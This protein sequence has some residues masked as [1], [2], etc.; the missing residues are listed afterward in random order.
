MAMD[1]TR[2]F[3]V[4]GGVFVESGFDLGPVGQCRDVGQHSF[5][6]VTASLF[7]DLAVDASEAA[8][9][10][11]LEDVDDAVAAQHPLRLQ[12]P[13]EGIVPVS[14]RGAPGQGL[15][16]FRRGEPSAGND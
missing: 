12:A 1:P 13:P 5:E 6:G 8:A 11:R 4:S 10:D 16:V 3:V 9:R 7:E 14:I 15:D 2:V